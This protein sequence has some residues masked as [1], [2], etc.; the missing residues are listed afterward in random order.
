MVAS[1]MWCLPKKIE[2]NEP[3]GKKLGSHPCDFVRP[4]LDRKLFNVD[5]FER[6]W[7]SGPSYKHNALIY[8]VKMNL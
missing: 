7:M 8:S 5:I 1:L 3:I 4:P 2:I 6:S